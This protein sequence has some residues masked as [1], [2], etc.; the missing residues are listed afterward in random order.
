MYDSG[1][2]RPHYAKHHKGE[3]RPDRPDRPRFTKDYDGEFNS[4]RPAR[5]HLKKDR[6]VRDI[7]KKR[8][9]DARYFERQKRNFTPEKSDKN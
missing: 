3:F 8:G 7:D 4:D 2:N 1:H 6:Q 5:P 9:P